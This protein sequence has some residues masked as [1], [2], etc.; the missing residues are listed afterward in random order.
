M[1]L[2][3]GGSEDHADVNQ[4]MTPHALQL[5]RPRCMLSMSGGSAAE[6]GAVDLPAL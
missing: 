3:I 2:R 6:L 4:S 5:H 1:P